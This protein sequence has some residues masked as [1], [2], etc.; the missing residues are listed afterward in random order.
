MTHPVLEPGT[1]VRT[2]TGYTGTIYE[3]AKWSAWDTKPAEGRDMRPYT[4]LM[5]RGG[6]FSTYRGHELDVIAPGVKGYER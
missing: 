6:H 2:F 5:D 1:R 4:V 3:Q